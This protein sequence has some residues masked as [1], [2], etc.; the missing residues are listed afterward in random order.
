MEPA[1]SNYILII[2]IILA[3]LF[4]LTKKKIPNL[5]T[6]PVMVLG[7]GIYTFFYGL[8]GFLF[9][10]YGLLLGLVV[11]FIPFALGGMGAGDVKFLGAIG[12]LTGA[13]FVFAASVFAAIC[14]G[15]IAIGYMAY[16]G[17][18]FDF[19]R[20]IFGALALNNMGFI[21]LRAKYPF[22]DR[23]F[24]Y[25]TPEEK[26]EEEKPL[27][28]PYGVAIGLG[29]VLALAGVAEGLFAPLMNLF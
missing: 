23:V 18:L 27:Y 25:L 3:V 12:A 11:F 16:K 28:F 26:E 5:L 19:V 17:R 13:S 7:L 29:A 8:D 20:K 2:L 10:L 21:A 1:L 6:F 9:S 24:T 22:M 4:D 14:G 15:V